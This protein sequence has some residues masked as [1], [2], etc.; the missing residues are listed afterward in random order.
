MLRTGTIEN[1]VVASSHGRGVWSLFDDSDVIVSRCI[2]VGTGSQPFTSGDGIAFLEGKAS[3][4]NTL[5]AGN[6]RSGV[7]VES[8]AGDFW[9]SIVVRNSDGFAFRFDSAGTLSDVVLMENHLGGIAE[10]SANSDLAIRNNLFYGNQTNYLD[11][12]S[13]AYNTEFE[14]NNLVGNGTAPV[15]NN[16]VADP[17]FVGGPTGTNS[18]VQ[19]DSDNFQWRF[20]VSCGR[21][22]WDGVFMT[23]ESVRDR[24]PSHP[25]ET[26]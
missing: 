8:L 15:A 18:D 3:M 1:T 16:I 12:A 11:E 14:I 20:R 13:I 2:V 4:A 22:R 26:G 19:Y 6:A 7:L 23:N 9:N 24:G 10:Y 5:V 21:G 17:L 25:G